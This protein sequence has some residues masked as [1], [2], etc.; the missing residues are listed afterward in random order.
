MENKL[1]QWIEA[2]KR[3]LT[4]EDIWSSFAIV[5]TMIIISTL[6]LTLMG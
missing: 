1:K 4:V 2:L 3:E 5:I 6:V